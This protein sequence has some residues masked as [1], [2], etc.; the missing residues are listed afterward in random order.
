[1]ARRIGSVEAVEIGLRVKRAR[2]ARGMTL[3]QVAARCGGDYT[4]VS[5]IERGKFSSLNAY[6]QKLCTEL[7]IDP[8]SDDDASPQALH[9]RLD[10]L[11]REKPA[12]ASAL[13]AVF[14]AF[15]RLAN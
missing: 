9:A 6:V 12:A 1:M 10:R 8:A 3:K 7:Q 13:H 11:I 5:K 4:Q 15:D 2:V 14:D